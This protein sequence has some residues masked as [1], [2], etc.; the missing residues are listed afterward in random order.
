MH[1]ALSLVENTGYA[2]TLGQS[3]FNQGTNV[4]FLATCRVVNDSNWFLGQIGRANLDLFRVLL[5]VPQ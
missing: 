5:D 3:R 4:A 2:S 1:V